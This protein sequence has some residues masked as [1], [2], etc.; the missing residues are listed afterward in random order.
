MSNN[1]NRKGV[2]IGL[3]EMSPIIK[4]TQQ[5]RNAILPAAI[6]TGDALDQK[7]APVEDPAAAKAKHDKGVGKVV[8]PKHPITG[9]FVKR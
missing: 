7:L 9:K 6:S 8:Q 5:H 2:D 1:F 3:V 4:A